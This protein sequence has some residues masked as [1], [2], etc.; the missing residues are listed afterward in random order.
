MNA[1]FLNLQAIGLLLAAGT[2]AADVNL[3]AGVEY[4]SGTYGGTEDIEDVYVPLSFAVRGD[5]VGLFVTVPYLSVRA[6]ARTV[7]D[8]DGQPIPGTGETTTESGLGDVIASVT[9]YDL[10]YNADSHFAVDARGSFKLGFAV[11]DRGLGTGEND[12]SLY[13]CVQVVR[14]FDAVRLGRLP[15]A[16]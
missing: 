14:S 3:S 9:V 2:V 6:P 16:G 5:R 13:R 4:S 1:N 11:A 7:I 12:L 10:Y 8:P 15:V